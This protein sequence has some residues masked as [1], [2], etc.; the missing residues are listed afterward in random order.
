MR[1]AS[2]KVNSQTANSIVNGMIYV[3]YNVKLTIQTK[4]TA[5]LSVAH[6]V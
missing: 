2:T 6:F 4:I 5:T 1:N 3:F